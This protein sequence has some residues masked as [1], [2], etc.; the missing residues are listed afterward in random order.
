MP[1]LDTGRILPAWWFAEL[2]KAEECHHE[3]PSENPSA[4]GDEEGDEQEDP[5]GTDAGA[6]RE[7]PE[8]APAR[9]PE[10]EVAAIA[11]NVP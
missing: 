3:D 8:R 7:D 5:G 11:E 6:H 1:F 10:P 2:P 9:A 4:T